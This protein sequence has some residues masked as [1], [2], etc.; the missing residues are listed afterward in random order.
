MRASGPC[1]WK[2]RD[3]ATGWPLAACAPAASDADEVTATRAVRA[4]RARLVIGRPFW[5]ASGTAER[6]G[7][8]QPRGTHRWV[9]TGDHPGDDGGGEAARRAVERHGEAPGL[10]RRV[11]D[12]RELAE[13][14]AREAAEGG[15][16]E[17][18]GDELGRDVLLRAAERTPQPY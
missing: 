3:R 5:I 10:R 14:H 2:P 15:Q 7:R 17:R 13:Q 18:L 16:E 12:R 6:F 4:R 9:G 8:R 11:D 1:A